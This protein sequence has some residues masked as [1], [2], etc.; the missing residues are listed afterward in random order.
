MIDPI[1]RWSLHNRTAVIA[2]AL[3]LTLL[4]LYT[5]REMPVDV[6]PDSPPRR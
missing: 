6:F 3:V 5:A 1:I 2:V 4:G